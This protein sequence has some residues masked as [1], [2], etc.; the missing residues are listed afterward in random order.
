MNPLLKL[1]TGLRKES[2]YIRGTNNGAPIA[3]RI[4]K[5]IDRY[6]MKR[7][8]YTCGEPWGGPHVDCACREKPMKLTPAQTKLLLHL[9][10]GGCFHA[11]LREPDDFVRDGIVFSER[12]GIIVHPAPRMI[13]GRYRVRN[14]TAGPLYLKK[15]VDCE[16]GTSG[17]RVFR[18]T[19]A[20][21][22]ALA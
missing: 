16:P 5:L 4:D 12:A 7:G 1:L 21:Q 2:S 10:E 8:H 20:G 22:D 15:L 19:I 14:Q 6:L 11:C 13:E 17:D 18:I 9:A 3:N